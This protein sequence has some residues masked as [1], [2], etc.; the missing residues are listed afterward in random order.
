MPLTTTV[1]LNTMLADLDEAVRAL[2]RRELVRHGFEGVEVV[3]DAPTKEWSASLSAPTV[4][5]FLYD[6]REAVDHRPVEWASR[7]QNGRTREVRPPLRMDASFAVTAWTR[8]VQDEHRLLSQVLAVLY[9]FPELP[10]ELLSGT[11]AARVDID[12]PLTTRVGQAKA[13]GKADFWSAVGGQYKAS[14][15]YVVSVSCEPGTEVERGPQV[16]TQTVRARLTGAGVHESETHRSGG[17]VADGDGHPVAGV[18]VAVP[19]LGR[20]AAADGDGRFRL[21]HLPA[22]NH[23][24]VAR[25]PDGT[26]A[27]GELIVPGAGVDLVLG[28][29]TRRAK[30]R[31]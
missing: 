8:E 16:R 18:W 4:N 12:Y 28:A 1:P 19:G 24:C 13:D 11:L 27:E 3:F 31:R 23:R 30:A 2:L 9:A 15:D 10:S 17:V 14:L 21:D 20:F 25:G 22:G 7:R 6:L 5:L 29:T 26:E